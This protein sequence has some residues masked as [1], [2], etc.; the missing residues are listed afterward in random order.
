LRGRR[1]KN[2]WCEKYVADPR[3]LQLIVALSLT[4]YHLIMR[5]ICQPRRLY[6]VLCALGVVFSISRRVQR[7]LFGP[8]P[9]FLLVFWQAYLY[10][11]DNPFTCQ[12]F[13]ACCPSE[14]VFWMLTDRFKNPQ[15]RLNRS[16]KKPVVAESFIVCATRSR[17][18][19]AI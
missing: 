2:L 9:F 11:A 16:S 7:L 12:S 15:F 19:K 14:Y 18:R 8:V 13:P 4:L 1:R 5:D 6:G 10:V 17:A 3:Y